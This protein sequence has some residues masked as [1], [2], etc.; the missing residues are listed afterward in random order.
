MTFS[1]IV[2]TRLRQQPSAPHQRR[3]SE[4]SES[5]GMDISFVGPLSPV[6]TAVGS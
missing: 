6:R 5:G 2:P 1:W 4:L 3:V